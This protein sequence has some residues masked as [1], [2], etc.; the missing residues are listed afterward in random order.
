MGLEP[1][2]EELVDLEGRLGAMVES[3]TDV[4]EGQSMVVTCALCQSQ[5][6]LLV[7]KLEEGCCYL[8]FMVRKIESVA[9]TLHC[10]LIEPIC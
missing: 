3:L 1:P 2:L 7:R 10:L 8:L 4:S 5:E 9:G 6:L